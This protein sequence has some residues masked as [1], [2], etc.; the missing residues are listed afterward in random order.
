MEQQEEDMTHGRLF[1][2][3]VKAKGVVLLLQVASGRYPAVAEMCFLLF[4]F[5]QQTKLCSTLR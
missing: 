5:L 2:D 1:T 4:V 3:F